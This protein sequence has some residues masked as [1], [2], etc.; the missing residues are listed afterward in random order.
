[1]VLQ[2]SAPTVLQLQAPCCAQLHREFASGQ[3]R[4][5][6]EG[7]TLG[8]EMRKRRIRENIRYCVAVQ[9]WQALESG[10]PYIWHVW[11]FLW[12]AVSR[13]SLRPGQGG[14]EIL[15]L[16]KLKGGQCCFPEPAGLFGITQFRDGC[17]N[18]CELGDAGA[19]KEKPLRAS[20]VLLRNK[21]IL[22]WFFFFLI[23]PPFIFFLY[24]GTFRN[25]ASSVHFFC[26]GL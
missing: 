7:V 14:A 26:R 8:F 19:G 5:V 15:V 18:S 9:D 22:W 11:R 20:L 24:W 1:M 12:E 17:D 21:G 25:N 13:M 16:P 6:G 23:F 4:T 3:L 10:I 2:C